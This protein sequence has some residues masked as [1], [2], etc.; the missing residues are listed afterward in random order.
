MSLSQCGGV[1][2]QLELFQE[3]LLMKQFEKTENDIYKKLQERMD[4]KLNVDKLVTTCRIFS[5]RCCS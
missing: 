4:E 2:R 3:L 1:Y 5:I